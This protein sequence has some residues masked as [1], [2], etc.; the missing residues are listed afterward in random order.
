MKFLHVTE[1]QG[2]YAASLRE[3]AIPVPQP[4]EL[5][6]RVAASGVNRADLSQIAGHYPPPPGEPDILGLEVAGTDDAT[7]A[8]V[9]ALLG[10]GGHAEYVAAPVG[11]VFAAPPELDPTVAAGIPE[12]FLTAF[13]NLVIEGSLAAGATALVHAGASGVGLA[14]IQVAKLCGAR[15]AAT[16]RTREKL[17]ALEA[18]GADL[19]IDAAR[20]DF[21]AA[22]TA[23]WGADPVDV[24]LDPVGQASLAGDLRVLA[25]GGRI[26]C[27]AT[28]SGARVELD[29]AQLM[30]KRARL[31]GSTLRAR[32]RAEKAALVTRFC[33]EILPA[34]ASGALRVTLDSVFPP[35]RAADAFQRMREN[36]N[37][38]KIVIAW[39]GR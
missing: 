30:R 35:R 29:L 19:A 25:P 18:A 11:Q 36:R 9:C 23:R 2:R 20:G 1:Q 10:G 21:A 15:V 28:M 33:A 27:I 31:A 22:I 7:G 34:L 26:V 24:V 4:G 16:T 37:V 32:S 8:T 6:I 38:G 5:L 17:P 14:A 39:T 12:A 13:V 3:T